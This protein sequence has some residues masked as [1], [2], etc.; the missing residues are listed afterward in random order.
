MNL[1]SFDAKRETQQLKV[2][3][4][5]DNT[6]RLKEG[7]FATVPI[8]TADCPTRNKNLCPENAIATMTNP[9]L[10][11]RSTAVP[12]SIR[13]Y[14]SHEETHIRKENSKQAEYVASAA[15]VFG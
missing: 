3:D 6:K 4:S 7:G 2:R 12:S 9:S 13:Q 11:Y 10:L 5:I 15:V 1:I 14:S 8:R